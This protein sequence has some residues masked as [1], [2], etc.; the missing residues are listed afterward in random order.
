MFQTVLLQTQTTGAQGNSSMMSLIFMVGI[1]V[2]FYFFMI[3][4][5]QRR[6]KEQVKY[7]EAVKKGDRVVTIGG[8]H[9]KIVELNNDTMTLE[10]DKGVKLTFEKS[11]ISVEGTKRYSEDNQKTTTKIA[12]TISEN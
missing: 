9:G 12:E 8:L 3:R 10:V 4:P 2:V 11:A 5:Q 7:R 6:Q 1:F